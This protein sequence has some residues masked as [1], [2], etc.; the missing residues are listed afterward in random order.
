MPRPL[1]PPAPS[2]RAPLA[3]IS[4]AVA[5]SALWPSAATA[6]TAAESPGAGGAEFAQIAIATTG[7]TVLTLVLLVLGFGHRS[8][9]V[10][11]LGAIGRFAERQSGL[12]PWAALPSAFA[13]GSLLVAVFGMYWDIA[14]HIDQGR[15]AGPL[16]NP[17]HYFI[18]FGLF[19]IF[20]AGWLAIVL[21]E[22]GERPGASA[23]RITKDWYAPLGGVLICACGA[24]ALIGFPLD[25]V[26]HRLFGQDVTLWGPT[27]LMLIGGASMTLIG[28]A[29][30]TVEAL[31]F[32]AANPSRRPE[33]AYATYMRAIAS[34]GGFMLGLSTFQA[35][36][37]FGVPQFRFVLEPVMLML[38]AGVGLVAVRIWAGKGAAIGAALFFLLIRGLLALAVG[39][40][41]G[42]TTPVMPLYVVEAIVVELVALRV[43]TSKPLPFALW[44]G[45]GIGTF[46]LAAEWGWSHLV[47]PI[48]FP[49]TL[50]GSGV[51]FGI[52]A[53]FSGALVGAW[54]GARI[55]EVPH[56]EDR[57]L[58]IGAVV[59]A[60]GIAA[61]IAIGLPKPVEPGT[62]ATVQLTDVVAPADTPAAG[63]RAVQAV[64]T[65]SPPKAADEAKWLTVTAWQGDG[66]VV[67]HLEKVSQG[68]Y[69]TTQPI[70]VH[71]DWK[72]LIR[73]HVGRGLAAVPIFLPADAAIKAPETPALAQFSRPF[74]ADHTVLQRE[75]RPAAATITLLAY[76][77]VGGIAFALLVLLV[78]GLHRLSVTGR[79]P[80]GT[81]HDADG[82]AEPRVTSTP[83][84]TRAASVPI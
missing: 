23:I 63:G 34:T 45:L 81:P 18:L 61:L 29:A 48:P 60:I 65:L 28:I 59:G 72:A 43:A 13:G 58:R 56:P 25:D 50:V 15:D 71:D 21:P 27:H 70:P 33:L 35:E 51:P 36:F 82:A 46:G 53:A 57:P 31:R 9:K 77:V 84:A 30:L 19:G 11:I 79:K 83:E 42:E 69:R 38:A 62:S 76:L 67:D 26:W 41:L 80:T 14:L 66:F 4:S 55:K 22:K 52:A 17:A 5:A 6:A 73:L 68:V 49:E 37:D 75:Q 32:N 47:A 7:A 54:I 40:G 78:W 44:C 3:L 74:V 10:P 24:F 20:S 8:G 39:P 1:G 12:P 16:A 2:P 64:V